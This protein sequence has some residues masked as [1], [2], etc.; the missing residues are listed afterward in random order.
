MG[1]QIRRLKS[2]RHELGMFEPEDCASA[3]PENPAFLDPWIPVWFR[4]PILLYR[5]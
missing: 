5:I 3:H 4:A 1:V 2:G